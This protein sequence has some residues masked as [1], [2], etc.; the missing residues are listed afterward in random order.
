MTFLGRVTGVFVMFA[1]SGIIGALASIL[2]GMLVAP[3]TPEEPTLEQAPG[4]ALPASQPAGL[5]AAA[6]TP[7]AA[8]PGADAAALGA[9]GEELAHLRAEIAALRVSFPADVL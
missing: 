5:A 8:L 7:S 9:T 4:A 3:A 2:A 6:D 1:G